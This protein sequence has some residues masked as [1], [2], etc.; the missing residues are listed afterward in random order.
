MKSRRAAANAALVC[1]AVLWC[2][3]VG[4][5]AEVEHVAPAAKERCPVCGMFV[6]GH[7]NWFAG[8]LFRD[9]S[10][11]TFDGPKDL[12]KY[13]SDIRKYDR[14]RGEA[15]VTAAYVTDYYRV[16]PIDARKAFYVTKSDVAGPMGEEFVPFEKEADAAEFL[17]DHR[18]NAILRY[19]EALAEA[20]AL[21]GKP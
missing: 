2:A 8:V 19:A 10:H 13:L 5:G 7:S 11:A 15:D 4:A 14:K 20:R 1:L 16:K 12:F 9:R 21:A 17:R 6:Q 3:R 18:G